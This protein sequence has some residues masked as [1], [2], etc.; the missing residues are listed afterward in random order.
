MCGC[1]FLFFFK[2]KTAYEMRISDWSSDVCSSD[3]QADL[4]TAVLGARGIR[5]VHV[6]AHGDGVH[7]VGELLAR[8][9]EE[10]AQADVPQVLSAMLLSAPLFF[11]SAHS[12]SKRL[13][14]GSLAPLYWQLTGPRGFGRTF[15]SLFG[16]QTRPGMIELHDYWTLIGQQRGKL[17]VSALYRFGAE[18]GRA[19]V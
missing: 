15:S 1:S 4:V 10:G 13:L 2:Q 14:F 7:V 12:L 17:A 6:V 16:A 5:H 11:E 18:I 19:H 3:L 9:Q 8:A